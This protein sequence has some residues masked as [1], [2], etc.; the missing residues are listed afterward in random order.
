MWMWAADC[1][2]WEGG[3]LCAGDGDGVVDYGGGAGFTCEV[4]GLGV[5]GAV[6]RWHCGWACSRM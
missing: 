6:E 1:A 3:Y 5:I 2:G 4:E